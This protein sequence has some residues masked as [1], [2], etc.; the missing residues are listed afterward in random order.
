M[1]QLN[2]R[3]K[4]LVVSA[5][6]VA[7]LATPVILTSSSAVADIAQNPNTYSMTMTASQAAPGATS[8]KSTTSP[9]AFLAC[10]AVANRDYTKAQLNRCMSHPKWANRTPDASQIRSKGQMDS[11]TALKRAVAQGKIEQLSGSCPSG[12]RQEDGGHAWT[13]KSMMGSTIYK[14]HF[15]MSYCFNP[16]SDGISG[17]ITKVFNL[18]DWF[19]NTQG[20]V[21]VKE[22]VSQN[23]GIT[24]ATPGCGNPVGCNTGWGRMERHV[25]LCVFKY[26]CY[27]DVYPNGRLTAYGFLNGFTDSGT[28]G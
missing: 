12:S 10:R 18:R 5:G 7:S 11:M 23:H 20:I 13:K 17:H 6:L 28:A 8:A 22:I 16:G 24:P 3:A 15:W 9:A 2:I 14:W 21:Q 1:S 26:G 27:T 19:T 4:S 25:Q